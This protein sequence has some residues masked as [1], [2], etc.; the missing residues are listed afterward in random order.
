MVDR[1]QPTEIL[2]PAEFR[3]IREELGLSIPELTRLL[4]IA[5]ARSVRRWEEGD[6][7]VSGPV[8]LLMRALV[9]VNGLYAYLAQAA[10]TRGKMP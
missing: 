4:N 10:E 3:R 7:P 5:T 1:T 8:T 2:S 9:D 6:T